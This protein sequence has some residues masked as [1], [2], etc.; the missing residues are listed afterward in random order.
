MKV[1]LFGDVHGNLA[2]LE[3]ALAAL[4]AERP[5][6]L[7]C[8]GDVAATGPQ[9]RETLRR[10]RE[11]G[12]P[13]VLGNADAALLAPPP[14]LPTVA[15][16]ATDADARRIAAI[17][18]WCADQLDAAD[19]AYVEAFQATVAV[20]L[21]GGRRLLCFHGSPGSS[22]DVI[23][24]TTPDEELDRLLAGHA[25]DVFAGGHWHFRLLR[26]HRGREVVNPGSVG[27]PYLILPDG[28][29]RVPAW[30][31]FALLHAP[32]TGPIEVA[33]RRVPYDQAATVRA[34]VERGMP[35][36]GWWTVDW[37]HGGD[38]GGRR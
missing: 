20:D 5:D 9:P 34:M 30:A 14:K 18:R 19:R 32:A 6:R 11:V 33:F 27:L 13:V 2:A 7:V 4:A 36:A 26:N 10:L 3:A 16:P 8:L 24:A 35:H 28:G 15:P 22:D 31:E 17:D 1:G 12:C 38:E 23:A 21:G 25:A 29:A 37:E